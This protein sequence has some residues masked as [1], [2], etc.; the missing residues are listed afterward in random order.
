MLTLGPR[1]WN[2]VGRSVIG[3]VKT[4]WDEA[5]ARNLTL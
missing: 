5:T 4:Q 1:C 3:D 2:F